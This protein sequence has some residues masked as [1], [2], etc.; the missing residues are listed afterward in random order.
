MNFN[1]S[2][3]SQI[4]PCKCDRGSDIGLYINC[5][6]GNL[7]TLSI[8]F[9]NIAGLNGSKVEEVVIRDSNFVNLYGTLFHQSNARILKIYDVPIKSI[10]DH[11][12]W[13][14]NETLEELRIINSSLTEFPRDAF[15]SLGNLKFLELNYHS[16]KE[17]NNDE[18]DDS[19]LPAKL[20]KMYITNGNVTE[21]G[22]NTFQHL[23]KLKTIDLHGNNIAVLKKNQFRG[24]RDVELLD[25]SFNNIAKLD[26]S[27][28]A[29]LTKLA[30]CNVS[31][32]RLTELSRGAFTRNAVLKIV[33]LAFNNIKRLDANSLRGMRFLR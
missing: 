22:A 21:I 23:K 10:Q 8:A 15:K 4:F 9:Q 11:V 32:N 20:E 25:I 2:R 26:S 31:N 24:L 6:G 29:D 3:E 33:N 28:I 17:L 16:I 1:N 27:H 13:G 30:F 19:Q 5:E 7:A 12:F 18:F 14:I